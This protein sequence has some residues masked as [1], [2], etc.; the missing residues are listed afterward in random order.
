V[1]L[2]TAA[3]GFGLGQHRRDPS[4]VSLGYLRGGRHRQ[5]GGFFEKLR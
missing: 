4:R 5:P 3:R 1:R 2:R